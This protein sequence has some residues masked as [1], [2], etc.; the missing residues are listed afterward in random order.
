MCEITN[1]FTRHWMVNCG[2]GLWKQ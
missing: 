2:R 1:V